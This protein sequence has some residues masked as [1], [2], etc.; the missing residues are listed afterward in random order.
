MS[1]NLSYILEIAEPSINE[2]V[3]SYVEY[4]EKLKERVTDYDIEMYRLDITIDLIKAFGKYIKDTDKISNERISKRKGVLLLSCWVEREGKNHYFETERIIA[5]GMIQCRHYRYIAKTS[6][7][8]NESHFF[9]NHLVEKQKAKTKIQSITTQI[10]TT[11][12][13]YERNIL[14]I[15]NKINMTDNEVLL[16]HHIKDNYVWENLNSYAHNSYGTKENFENYKTDLITKTITEHR[17]S[18][19]EKR[20]EAMKKELQKSIDKL[21]IKL[22]IEKSKIS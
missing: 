20:I 7:L 18:H 10:E 4:K 6:L 17:N 8:S 9:I 21:N 2:M 22:N 3:L 12:M 13:N 14:F 11:R 1:N 5:S 15:Q 19:N 16:A